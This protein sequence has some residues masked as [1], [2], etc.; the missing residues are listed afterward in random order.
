MPIPQKHTL[1]LTV[2]VSVI[3]HLLLFTLLYINK[4]IKKSPLIESEPNP[5]IAQLYY[6][7]PPAEPEI[8]ETLP[9][10]M[11]EELPEQP[12]PEKDPEP[13]I[14][15]PELL[16][17]IEEP[18]L[19]EPPPAKVTPLT[20]EQAATIKPQV[21]QPTENTQS[22]QD[23]VAGQLND[24]RQGKLDNLAAQAAKEYRK[25]LTSPTL[26]TKPQDSFMTE[27][28]RFI[29]KVTTSVDCSSTTNQTLAIVMGLMGG[30]VKCSEPP[31]FDS[32]IQK[33]LNKTAELPALQQ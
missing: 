33:R 29:Q 20:K 1:V 21:A 22:V 19:V 26:L 5:I 11:I 12:S 9:I 14:A 4:Q 13:Q 2:V 6:Y 28:E 30:A 10:E 32:F 31:P 24:Y 25:Q 15:E 27:E 18:E 17:E 3:I 8:E 7:T 23:L 16:E